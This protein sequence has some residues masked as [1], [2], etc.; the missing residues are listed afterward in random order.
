[1]KRSFKDANELRRHAL[2]R[3][4]PAVVNG[5]AFNAS[6]SVVELKRAAL[7]APMPEPE[8][9]PVAPVLSAA[10]VLKIVDARIAKAVSEN[11]Q[12]TLAAIAGLVKQIQPVPGREVLRH[13]VHIEYGKNYVITDMTITPIY[14]E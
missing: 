3:G 6:G 10:S 8:P 4:A 1:M 11:S 14:K 9:K 13:K 12:A 5:Q 2:E 7:A